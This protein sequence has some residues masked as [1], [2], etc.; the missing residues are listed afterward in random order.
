MVEFVEEQYERMSIGIMGLMEAL[1]EGNSLQD[2]LHQ[3]DEHEVG[4]AKKTNWN[5]YNKLD[6]DIT[7][8][9]M[10]GIF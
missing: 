3:V 5:C 6:L 4:I 9:L 7:Q 2:K 1:K 8:N 10:C